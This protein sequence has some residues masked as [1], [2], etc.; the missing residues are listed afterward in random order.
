MPK[1]RTEQF[2]GGDWT[3]IRD[4]EPWDRSRSAT[5]TKASIPAA[6]YPNGF[7][8]SGYPI[9]LDSNG[10][11]TKYTAALGLAGFVLTDSK[12]TDDAFVNVA[13]YDRGRVNLNRLP[14]V[15]GGFTPPTNPGNFTFLTQS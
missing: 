5:I 6:D 9:S 15:T 1:M 3:W 13:L 2:G 12:V 8:P 11:G 7:I 10:I 14:A 4:P